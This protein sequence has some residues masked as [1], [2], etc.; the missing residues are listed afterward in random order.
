MKLILSPEAAKQ[1]AQLPKPTQK[2]AHKQFSLL[3]TNYRYPSL[4]TRKMGGENKFEARIDIH[5][6]FTFTVEEEMIYVLII[7]PHDTG[8]GKK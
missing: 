8:L 2:K 1:L 6:R 7:G 5:Y 4:R 3:L